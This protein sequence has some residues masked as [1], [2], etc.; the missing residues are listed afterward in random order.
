MDRSR[1]ISNPNKYNGKTELSIVLI[2][3][4]GTPKLCKMP[5]VKIIVS[6][7]M[8]ISLTVKKLCNKLITIAKYF[9]VKDALSKKKAKETRRQEKKKQKL[10]REMAL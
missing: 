9:P 8:L 4:H 1:R 3:I 2:V 6:K 7:S 10:S 5:T